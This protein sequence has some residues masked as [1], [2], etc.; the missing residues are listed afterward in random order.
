MLYNHT[1]MYVHIPKAAG[2]TL[3][4]VM[5][6]NYPQDVIWKIKSDIV[7]DQEKLGKLEDEEKRKIRVVFGHYCYGLHKALA[8]G[9]K[10]K[11]VTIL[12]DPVQRVISLYAYA[13]FGTKAHYLWEPAQK[14]GLGEFVESGVALVTDNA[15]VRQLCGVDHFTMTGGKEGERKQKPYDDMLIPFGKV[16]REHLEMAKAN[17]AKF[18]CVGVSEEFDKF[19]ACMQQKFGWRVGYYENKN[20]TGRKPEVD[21]QTLDIV[22][23]YC[24]L[25]YELYEFGRKIALGE[26]NG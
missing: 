24:I 15:Q 25:D 1:I 26:Q 16:T 11:Y 6:R 14:M 19:L 21:H 20:V 9:Q 7:G 23:R 2:T 18:A 10:F 22:R 17:L 12:R 3:R 8:K 5:D 4:W 13:K